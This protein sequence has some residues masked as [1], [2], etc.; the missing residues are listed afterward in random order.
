[1]VPEVVQPVHPSVPTG[2]TM[3]TGVAVAPPVTL[4]SGARG[5]GFACGIETQVQR[6]GKTCPF[7]RPATNPPNNT[8]ARKRSVFR[9]AF[10]SI[11]TVS[12]LVGTHC[13][14]W[15]SRFTH[16]ITARTG[17]YLFLGIWCESNFSLEACVYEPSPCA[18]HATS[19]VLANPTT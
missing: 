10:S 8:A 9:M 13:C 1:M 2:P 6:G 7:T 17:P 5:H 12:G 15:K 4:S 18:H 11:G 3:Q 19:S 14:E 16:R